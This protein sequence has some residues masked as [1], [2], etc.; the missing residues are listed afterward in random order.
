MFF[1]SSIADKNYQAKYIIATTLII[2]YSQLKVAK[3][4]FSSFGI[5]LLKKNG[6]QVKSWDGV[7]NEVVGYSIVLYFNTT[8]IIVRNKKNSWLFL[9]VICDFIFI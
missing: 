8:I 7:H 2:I 5:L 4:I 6:A 3:V 9:L 1:F